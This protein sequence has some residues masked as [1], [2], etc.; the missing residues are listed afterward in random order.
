[1]ELIFDDIRRCDASPIDQSLRLLLL[2]TLFLLKLLLGLLPLFLFLLA[3][4]LL[5]LF[6]FALLALLV[7]LFLSVDPAR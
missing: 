4:T 6:A 2:N 3:F 1:M 7:F 5:V